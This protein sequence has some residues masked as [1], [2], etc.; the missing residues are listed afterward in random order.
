MKSEKDCVL[1]KIAKDTI[2]L[3]EISDFLASD[4]YF[5]VWINK[6]CESAK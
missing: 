3:S 6:M 5:V 2:L 4:C 1:A